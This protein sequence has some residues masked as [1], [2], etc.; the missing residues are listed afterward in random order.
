[1]YRKCTVLHFTN[2]MNSRATRL[3]GIP[4]DRGGI[5]LSRVSWLTHVNTN[6]RVS[7]QSGIKGER[8]LLNMKYTGGGLPFKYIYIIGRAK[9]SG[10]K[11][12]IL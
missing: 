10:K 3:A 5:L 7:R 4:A 11:A 12:V 9:V 8:K 6:S 2:Y 1:M